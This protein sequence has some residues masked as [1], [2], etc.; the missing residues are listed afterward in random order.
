MLNGRLSTLVDLL[1]TRASKQS[2][3][4][5][6]SFLLGGDGKE[7]HWTYKDLDR[8]AR[9]IGVQ[10]QRQGTVGQRALLLYPPGL[11]YIA[12]FFGCLYA[13]IIAVP[14]YPP[15]LNRPDLRLKTVA[16]DAQASFVLTT[17]AIAT[18]PQDLARRLSYIEELSHLHWLASGEIADSLAAEWCT[19]DIDS[20]TPAFLQYTSGSTATPRGVVLT[21]GN[22]LHNLGLIH[23]CF[24]VT[25]STR[26]VIWLPPYHDMG[27]IGGILE[28]LYVG[29]PVT[30]MSPLDFLQRPIQWLAAIARTQA[31]ISGGPNFAYDLCVRKITPEQR[32]TL[33]LSSWQLAFNGA[34]S[35][36]HETLER[37]AQVFGPCGFRRESFYPCYGLAEATL[38]VSGGRKADPP[39]IRHFVTTA[40]ERKHVVESIGIDGSRTLVGCGQGLSDQKIVIV[41]PETFTPCP[42][43][44]MGEVWIA[45]PSVAQGYWNRPEETARTFH[46]HLADVDEG[47]FLRTGDLGFIHAG[48]LFIAGRLKDLIIIRGHNYDPQDIELSVEQSHPILVPGGGAAFSIEVSGEERLVIVQ[49]M[50]RGHQDTDPESVVHTIRQAVSEQHGLQTYAVVL[51]RIHSIPKTSSGKIQ[52]HICRAQF[53]DGH[54]EAIYQS[55]LHLSPTD[56]SP[57]RPSEQRFIRKAVTEIQN[58]E[59][60]RSLLNLFLQEQV[61]NVL[62]VTP[63]QIDI[64]QPLSRYRLDTS[65]VDDLKRNI[66]INLE[67][68]L[69]QSDLLRCFSL[70]QWVTAILEQMATH[71]AIPAKEK[72]A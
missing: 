25:P 56:G 19:S 53:L 68:V 24:E 5:A 13:G 67:V 33:D 18:S 63:S 55:V 69:P 31:T 48:E 20:N 47:P 61:G 60:R 17:A 38:I 52:R 34:E 45:G 72:Q 21:H 16:V 3:Q 29:F 66:E 30:L 37:F 9:A 39:V 43:G 8:R 4:T 26:G 15:R 12:A 54:L 71:G 44:Q 7:V 46:A 49:E 41:D 42:P 14:V 1:R 58:P 10:L 36:H 50:N 28:P 23:T 57:I 35:I 11:E 22:L 65:A 59:A 32:A 62:R 40:Y 6:Y 27:L 64:L 70:A 51:V 2:D